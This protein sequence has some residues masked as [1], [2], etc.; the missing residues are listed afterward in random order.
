[1]RLHKNITLARDVDGFLTDREGRLLYHLAGQ[2]PGQ[3]VIVE[4]G[5]WKGKSTIWLGQGVKDAG[6][7]TRIYAIDPHTGS[8]EHQKDH[9]KIWTFDEFQ[10]NIARAGVADLVQPVVLPSARAA[11]SIPS[12]IELLF[13]DGAHDYESVKQDYMLYA[14]RVAP[15]GHIAF[16]DTPWPGVRQF[17]EEILKQPGLSKIYFTDTLL[18]ATKSNDHSLKN[19]IQAK[20]MLSLRAQFEDACNSKAP[21]ALRT[22]KKNLIK[23]LRDI[24]FIF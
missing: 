19:K 11:G 5:S 6:K 18:V 21:K 20:L 14:P 8:A 4:I 13:I 2:C 23:L 12:P 16:H 24:V 10:K 9:A 17:V 15:G 22:M 7:T 1:M 3:G